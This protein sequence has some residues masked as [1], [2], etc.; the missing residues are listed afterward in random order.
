LLVEKI[1]DLAL[2]ASGV[3][4]CRTGPRCR[5]VALRRVTAALDDCLG[6]GDGADMRDHYALR[7]AVEDPGGVMRVARAHPRDRRDADAECR[8]ADRRGR[9]GRGRV[10]LEVDVH[11]IE[12]A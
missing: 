2:G 5:T 4:E 10:V 1:V 11:R 9:L 12:V 3:A 6:L 8:D 7:S